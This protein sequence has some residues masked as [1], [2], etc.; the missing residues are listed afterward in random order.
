MTKSGK[1]LKDASIWSGGIFFSLFLLAVFILLQAN[2]SSI[3]ALDVKWLVVAALPLVIA[4]LRSNIIQKFKGFGI[5]LETRLQDPIG[6]IHL[7]AVN[8]LIDLP[9]DAKQSVN[10]LEN[11]PLTQKAN[12][13]R[14]TFQIQR[15]NYYDEGAIS[16]YLRELPNIRFF[17]VVNKSG[18]FIALLPVEIFTERNNP[19]YDNGLN[20][21]VNALTSNNITTSFREYAITQTVFESD[22]I[23]DAL[24]KVRKS[25][26]GLLPVTSEDGYLLGIVTKP[27]LESKVADEVL[28]TQGK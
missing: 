19:N 13:Q 8:A 27:M 23:L 25:K 26:F 4:L 2:N 28:L 16:F 21:F 24:R 15:E 18:K 3:L 5:E 6:S 22:N 10:Y 12:I 7:A 11:L 9:G 20:I 17:D 1:T 14:L